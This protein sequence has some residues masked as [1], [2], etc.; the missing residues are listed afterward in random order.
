MW[1]DQDVNAS[2]DA[3]LSADE[4]VTFEAKDHLVDGGRADAEMTLHVGLGR[5]L[6]EDACIDVDEGQVVALLF[7]EAMRA[8]A[9]H[10]A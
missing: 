5:G 4:A 6:V 1:W 7:R 9:A 3:R 10:D 8:G 2:G